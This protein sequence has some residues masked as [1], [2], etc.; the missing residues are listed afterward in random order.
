L[1]DVGWHKIEVDMDVMTERQIFTEAFREATRSDFWEMRLHWLSE[2]D[3]PLT[4]APTVD[5]THLRTQLARYG[6]K[7]NELTPENGSL[8]RRLNKTLDRVD[9]L[10]ANTEA[11]EAHAEV[12]EATIEALESE[13]QDLR[14]LRNRVKDLI[15]S[16]TRQPSEQRT[17]LWGRPLSSCQAQTKK[18]ST[19]RR[20]KSVWVCRY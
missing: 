16:E 13:V 10:K 18:K 1:D 9:A 11:L 3:V 8:K 20:I 15:V 4:M 5:D 19:T 14:L 17:M 6:K 12:L 7:I 2:P